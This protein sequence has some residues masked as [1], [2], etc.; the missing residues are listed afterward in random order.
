MP[1]GTL[2]DGILPVR[3]VV[4]TT[5]VRTLD[6]HSTTTK[7][8]QVRNSSLHLPPTDLQNLMFA[9]CHLREIVV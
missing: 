7:L 9:A 3:T 2:L 5:N 8:C 1:H 6:P 4:T